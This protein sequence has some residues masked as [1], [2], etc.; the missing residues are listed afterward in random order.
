M[1]LLGA[2]DASATRCFQRTAQQEFESADAV[3]TGRVES[4]R[5]GER[6]VVRFRTER[7]WKG[8]PSAVVDVEVLLDLGVQS[9][10]V[11]GRELVIF[12]VAEQGGLSSGLCS[13]N[14]SD[15]ARAAALGE[16]IRQFVLPTVVDS[17]ARALVRS[18]ES[19]ALARVLDAG[20]DPDEVRAEGSLLGLA[21]DRCDPEVAAALVVGG[22]MVSEAAVRRVWRCADG[23]REALLRVLAPGVSPGVRWSLGRMA[24]ERWPTGTARLELVLRTGVVDAGLRN[25]RSESHSLL[26]QA[27]YA[28]QTEQV[29]VLLKA[30]AQVGEWELAGAAASPS[31][32]SRQIVLDRHLG[33]EQATLLL[34]QGPLQDEVVVHLLASGADPRAIEECVP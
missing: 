3:F 31:A 11:P 6:L 10:V 2:P 25:P 15:L 30:G 33:P 32:A 12:A 28:G 21:V 27:L 14:T 4:I 22:A 1:A 34:R 29:A 23:D 17:E 26:R 8:H 13:G 7:W 5:R 16:P 9:S 24:L 18:G 19:A 20:A